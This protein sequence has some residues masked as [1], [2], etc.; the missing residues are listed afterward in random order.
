M[1][2]LLHP[3]LQKFV[4]EQIRAGHYDSPEAIINAA[5]ARLKTD[6]EF[7]ADE[8]RELR[9]EIAI[10]IE[11]ADRGEVSEWDP[12][13]LKRRVRAHVSRQEKAD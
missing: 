13:D 2:V 1:D 3:E 11:E 7:S 5:V 10:A 4:D 12:E 6:E 9:R 8:L